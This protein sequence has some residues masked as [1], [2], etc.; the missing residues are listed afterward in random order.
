MKTKLPTSYSD[1]IRQG[2]RSFNKKEG[3]TCHTH[4]GA[5]IAASSSCLSTETQASAVS[6]TTNCTTEGK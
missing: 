3:E 1:W 4:A 5:C 2:N 6:V